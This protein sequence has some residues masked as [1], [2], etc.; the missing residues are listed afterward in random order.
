MKKRWQ[1][2]LGSEDEGEEESEEKDEKEE[3]GKKGEMGSWTIFFN[4]SLGSFVM[5]QEDPRSWAWMGGV[6]GGSQL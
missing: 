6:W 4:D 1:L 3:K 2:E 5:L